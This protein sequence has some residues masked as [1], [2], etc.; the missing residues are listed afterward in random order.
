MITIGDMAF[1]NCS[2]LEFANGGASDMTVGLGN[3]ALTDVWQSGPSDK[4]IEAA[5]RAADHALLKP[6]A[7]G[8]TIDIIIDLADEQNLFPSI[9][10][11][12]YYERLYE[13]ALA[14]ARERG[15]DPSGLMD[16]AHIKWEYELHLLGYRSGNE[17]IK[18]RCERI[19]LNVE[20]TVWSMIEKGLGASA[21]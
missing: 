15:I 6:R 13:R 1:R 4:Q 2:S 7:D 20:E 16:V 18:A 5:T 19:D 10:S 3:E 8:S 9:A 14:L 21:Q 17:A 12:K 11:Q